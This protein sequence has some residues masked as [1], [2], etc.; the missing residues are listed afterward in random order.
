MRK[1]TYDFLY[2]SINPNYS[3]PIHRKAIE[4]LNEARVKLDT[5]FDICFK[6]AL[7]FDLNIY[8]S[9]AELINIWRSIAGYDRKMK[10]TT[11]FKVLEDKICNELWNNKK[12]LSFV[13]NFYKKQVEAFLGPYVKWNIEEDLSKLEQ[14]LYGNC[15]DY[16]HCI[17]ACYYAQSEIEYRKFS[18]E[19]SDEML[20]LE[21]KIFTYL[22]DHL[23]QI[24][25]ER[26]IKRIDQLI[27]IIGDKNEIL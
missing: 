14:I 11:I 6:T 8:P 19:H 16:I 4:F 21:S 13:T 22:T 3:I 20:E 10:Q 24:I 26:L 12:Y 18:N 23:G 17:H 27:Q 25:K 15:Y 1:K 7:L 2:Y 5:T 9:S